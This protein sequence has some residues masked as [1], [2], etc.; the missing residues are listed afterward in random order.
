MLSYSIPQMTEVDK[1]LIDAIPTVS[2]T[3]VSGN[4]YLIKPN[5]LMLAE[6]GLAIVRDVTLLDA[7][8]GE[9]KRP[10]RIIYTRQYVLSKLINDFLMPLNF[11]EYNDLQKLV[12]EAWKQLKSIEKAAHKVSD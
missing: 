9:E 2:Y 7:A 11:A 5:P 12:S 3:D 6:K 8:K 1:T 4:P 10:M